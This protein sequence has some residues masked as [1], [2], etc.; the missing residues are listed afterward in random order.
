[1][2]A[3][4][5][6]EALGLELL[7][8]QSREGL[9]LKSNVVRVFISST[10]SDMGRERDVLLDKAY[11][12]LQSFCQGLGLVFEV[13][14]MRWGVRDTIAVDHMTTEL[15]LQEIQSCKRMSVGP[16]FTV[17]LGNRYGY[18]PIPRL[19]P[20]NEF[21][22]LLSK[23]TKDQEGVGLLTDWFWKDDN[24]VPSTYVLQ[25]ITTHL[26]HYDD[27]RPESYEQHDNDV[28]TWRITEERILRLLRTAALQAEKDGAITT[29]QNHKFFK[30]VTEWEIE[31]GLLGFQKSDPYT[32]L[33]VR[34][35]SRLHKHESH[36]NF[37]QFVD[38]T[39]DGLV[40]KE[41]QELL[42]KLK[43]QIY[44]LCSGLVNVHSLELNRVGI[45]PGCKV[46]AK[47]LQSLCE[48]FVS[49]MKAKISRAV[50]SSSPASMTGGAEWGWLWQEISHHLLLSSNKCAVFCGRESLLGKIC[51]TM[52]ESTNTYH[53]PLVVYGPSGIG[54]TALM[55]KLAQEMQGV[56][57]PKSVVVQ[58]LLGTS[59][60]SSEIDSVL[61]SVCF[62]VCGAVGL[63]LPTTQTTNN[64]E[65]LVR[66][67]HGLLAQV[68]QQ[69]D[70]L[71]IILDSLDQLSEAN[72]AH[73]LHWLPKEIPPYVQI[74]VST[75]D[76]GPPL[77]EALR[78]MIPAPEN[79][80][81]VEQLG[82]DQGRE[83]IDAYM[84]A[85]GR[86]LTSD[87]RDVVLRGFQHCGHPL[88]LKLTLDTARRWASYTAVSE[89]QLGSTTQEAVSLLFQHLEKK[90]GRQ[91]ISA[92]LGYIVSSRDG[93]SEAELRDVLSLDDEVLAD[94]Y[95][96]WLPPSLAFIR[97]PPLLWSR[98]RHDLGEYLVERQ[99]H[100]VSVLGL[101]HRQF[102]EMV[103]ERY[104][105]V[106]S[107]AKSHSVLSD[108]FLGLWSQGKL[109]PVFLP[110]LTFNTK[111]N[112]DRKVSPQPLWFAQGVANTRKL[113]ELPYHL[114]HAGK[115]E[116]LHQEVI[117]STEWLCCK[118][119]TCGVAS[120]IEDL[121]L[122]AEASG[123]PEIGLIRDTFLLMKPTLDFI[124]GRMDLCLFYT[125]IFARLYTFAE[126]YP[127]LIG[128]LCSQCQDWFSACPNPVLVPS[129]SF[130][131]PPGGA[132]KTTLTGFQKGI[133]AVDLCVEKGLLVVGSEDGKVIAWN[134][135]ELEVIH[136]FTGHTAGI[137]CVKV[138]DRGARYL[139]SAFDGTLRL[140]SLLSGRQLYSI[141]I[142]CPPGTQPPTQIHVIEE[143]AVIYCITGAQ[144]NAWHLETSE[145]LFQIVLPEGSVSS[146]LGVL[147]GAVASLTDG[148]L[149]TFY[150][151]STGLGQKETC[152][153]VDQENFTPTCLLTLHR[154][155]KLIIGSKEGFLHLVSCHGKQTITKL[156]AEVSFLTTSDDEKLLCAGFANQVAVFHVQDLVQKGLH[157]VFRHEYTVLTAVAPCHRRVLITGCEDQTI[158]VWCL[159][160][161]D[162]LDTFTGM[163]APVTTL[164]VYEDTV[165]SMS[166]STYYLKLWHLDYNHKH[167]TN[168]CFPASSPLV[169]V[170]RSGDA[171]Y[172]LKHGDR[173][174]VV[175][176]DCRTGASS[177]P[178]TVSAEVSCLE[179]APQKKLLFC[180]L[181]TGTIL[182][183]PLAFAPETLCIPPP[184]TLPS[185]RCLAVSHL[186]DRVAVAYEGGISLFEITVRD[187]FP[188]IEGPLEK[189]PLSL[190]H[191]PISSMALLPNGRLL[192][193]T[194][195]G[196]VMLYDFKTASA[197]SLDDHSSEIT[198]ITVNHRGTH[199]LIGS[200]DSIQRLW[201]L[202]PLELNYTMDYKGFFFEG[203]LCATFSEDDR[204]IYT[205]SHD[206]TIK[207]WDA[208]NGRLLV[209][210]Y[211]Y[212]SVT[213]ILPF[214]D[215]FVAVSQL[216]HVIKE[217]FRCPSHISAEYNP[218]QN[219]RGQY[220][221]IS[222]SSSPESPVLTKEK[223]ESRP[224]HLRVQKTKSSHTCL[225]L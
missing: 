103:Q 182:I 198:C 108:Y 119:L 209:V 126:M 173:K 64:H 57:G 109:K 8:G 1:M 40:D 146:M 17:L 158:R 5:M 215:G 220:R 218:L 66:F 166:S 167:K 12:E 107:K 142:E 2:S 165:I 199:A 145:L 201:S 148:G 69:R 3:V 154:H 168:N 129:C 193:G 105:S 88:L 114:V 212:A 156:L 134:L 77:L 25:P 27:T 125:E 132:L 219:I 189:L 137:S 112:S 174:E 22:L 175:I 127:T 20:E 155:D 15:C 13:V 151:W 147:S 157:Q 44:A 18:R 59:P 216:G 84:R 138:I 99:T 208:S 70:S 36:R 144:L 113:R 214:K 223:E 37:A 217:R 186:E 210:Q 191:S 98:V 110:A 78:G 122:C 83:I 24:S 183:Y 111:L 23:L 11:P 172:F 135:D 123:C 39:A 150:D 55:C 170:S 176:W 190:L 16:T 104:L 171:V 14:D 207:V 213:K 81:L 58:R 178:I 128:R 26:P 52:W 60:L 19:I 180:G 72:H 41:A 133:T 115:W 80:F 43:T 9:E 224:I 149:L 76:S 91:L 101:Y 73:K 4:S 85:A 63:P 67:F 169:T 204:Y 50:G 143:K 140:W 10:F 225:L 62:Q 79:F 187:S 185:V 61:R 195:S 6:R 56:L 7:R 222:R 177:E 95:Q 90:H 164:V 48:Q 21:E 192:N 116:E 163:G 200:Q 54:K 152:L 94:V 92:A 160:T 49:Q 38:V 136:N 184:E 153:M 205:G 89:L 196:E 53:G 130:F 93:L 162:L 197:V 179:L 206:R 46:H 87:Q 51:L 102:I 211:V 106:E 161:G 75:V 131:Q 42:S 221:V 71:L 202:S 117:G 194:L 28:V 181:K 32:V 188:C 31:Q 33:F 139:S 100:G 35:L 74:V 82:V 29:E 96:Y 86:R 118:T 124:D 68:S 203:I 45:D 47:Y 65:D 141:S 97:L 121:S 159:S 34:E 30:S 120:V